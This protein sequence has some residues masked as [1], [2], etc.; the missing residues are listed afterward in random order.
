MTSATAHIREAI[1]SG[2]FSKALRLWNEYA[3]QLA[4]KVRGGVATESDFA[5]ARE[6]MEWSRSAVRVFRAHAAYQLYQLCTTR[7][8]EEPKTPPGVVVHTSC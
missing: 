8:Y 7:K 5:A 4:A 6:L 1:A 2:E 3:N